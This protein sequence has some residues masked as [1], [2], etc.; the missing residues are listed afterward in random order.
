[1]VVGQERM[2]ERINCRAAAYLNQGELASSSIAVKAE[3]DRLKV[4]VERL[5]ERW[6]FV[7]RLFWAWQFAQERHANMNPRA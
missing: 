3:L 1:M 6:N 7:S 4:E 5:P 2:S